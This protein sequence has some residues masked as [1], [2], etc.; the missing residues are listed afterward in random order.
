MSEVEP[1]K[2]VM[3][4]V[5]H[6]DD[7]EFG[8]AGAVALW[9]REGWDAYY[10]IC[11]DGGSGGPDDATDVSQAA[12]QKVVETRKQEQRN[13]GV[14]LGLK[15]VYFLGYPDGQ[16]EPSLALRRDIVRLLRTHKPARVICQSPDR[17]WSPT[18]IIQRYHHDHLAAGRAT[19]EAIYPSS[20]NPWDFPELMQ[21][22]LKPHKV[23]EIYIMGA[24]VENHTIDTTSVMD[25]K[26]RALHAHASQFAGGGEEVEQMLRS[27]DGENGK[28]H[29]YSYAES[30]HLVK[31]E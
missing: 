23:S 20:Q 15:D 12:R 29:N 21:E 8:C 30:F 26:M 1:N 2:V 6:E 25:V 4:I 22:G 19:L 31:N 18:F 3:V 9:V 16:L 11:A 7:A 28:Q 27:I 13:A 17:S 5:A 24:P 10:V 14:A